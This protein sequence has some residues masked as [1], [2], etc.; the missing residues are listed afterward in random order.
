MRPC[1]LPTIER[2]RANLAGIRALLNWEYD[3]FAIAWN[4]DMD[5]EERM[6]WCRCAKLGGHAWGYAGRDWSAIDPTH[7]TRIK[8]AV[9]KTAARAALLM[10]A[11]S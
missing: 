5:G 10:G 2:A 11:P 6:F 3:K 4:A 1:D 9:R 8:Q 7:Q